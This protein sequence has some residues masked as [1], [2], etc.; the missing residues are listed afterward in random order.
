MR[1]I[2][3]DNFQPEVNANLKNPDIKVVQALNQVIYDK[4]K[5]NPKNKK[6]RRRE[7]E[8]AF[9]MHQFEHWYNNIYLDKISEKEPRQLRDDE[10]A[11]LTKK[12]QKMA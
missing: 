10:F 3:T 1:G 2:K 8:L 5:K 6:E 12:Q 11:P 7:Q 9:S 4:R